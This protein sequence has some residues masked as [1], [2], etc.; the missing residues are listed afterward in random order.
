M[1]KGF[2]SYV[3]IDRVIVGSG[4][5][6]TGRLFVEGS[7]FCLPFR[8]SSFDAVTLFD[9]IEHLPRQT[10]ERAL[11]EAYRVLRVGG[12]LY[13][14]TPHANP[15][16]TPLDP[17]WCLGHRHYRRTTIRRILQSAGFTIDRMFV[18]GGVIESLDHVRLL[19]YKHL[20]HRQ[21]PSIDLVSRLIERS[22]GRDKRVGMTVFAV[23][24]R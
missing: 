24:S 2:R 10:E 1:S 13:F 23:A 15:V 7:V 3:G 14:S 21:V 18:A 22:H 9:V 5:A 17:V 4:P 8:D 11:T 20:L 12:K 19:V 16:H 6:M